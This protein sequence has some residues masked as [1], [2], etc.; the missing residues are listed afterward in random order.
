[1]RAYQSLAGA[2]PFR[3]L[4]LA[5][6]SIDGGGTSFDFM[7]ASILRISESMVRRSASIFSSVAALHVGGSRPMSSGASAPNGGRDGFSGDRFVR[8]AIHPFPGKALVQI[9]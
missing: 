3:D 1:M 9:P 2:F 6:R 7:R 4:G 5:G 8:M